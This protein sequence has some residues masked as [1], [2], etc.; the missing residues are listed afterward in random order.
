VWKKILVGLVG[1]LFTGVVFPIVLLLVQQKLIV[2]KHGQADQEQ[3]QE[4]KQ[5]KKTDIDKTPAAT[6]TT[7]LAE[8]TK[9]PQPGL[10]RGLGVE[11]KSSG[12]NTKPQLMQSKQATLQSQPIQ[13][14]PQ[15]IPK[16][17]ELIQKR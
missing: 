8:E 11:G 7:I 16:S 4:Q 9:P 3:E 1:G 6:S 15:P 14:A 5:T 12:A 17:K 13:P 10:A 2:D